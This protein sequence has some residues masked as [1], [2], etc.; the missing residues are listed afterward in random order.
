MDVEAK[1]ENCEAII[2]YNSNNKRLLCEALQTSGNG[3]VLFNNVWT[4]VPKNTR[5]AIHGDIA[6]NMALCRLWYPSGLSKGA[7]ALS[8][9]QQLCLPTNATAQ[10][11]GPRFEIRLRTPTLRTWGMIMGLKPV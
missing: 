3:A 4:Q 6:L 5:L 1:I 11:T 2:G 9:P 10:E 8:F 7:I